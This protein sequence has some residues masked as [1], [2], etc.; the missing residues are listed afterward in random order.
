[1]L[2]DIQR[3]DTICA[4]ATAMVQSSISIVRVSGSD[5]TDILNK[6]FL[7]KKGKQA[8]FVATLGDVID[9]DSVVV[10]EALCDIL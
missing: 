1:M 3:R 5:A 10:D 7:P 2:V 8:N 4:P 6:I 9:S